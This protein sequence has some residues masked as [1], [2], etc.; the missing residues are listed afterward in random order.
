LQVAIEDGNF[1]AFQT[2]TLNG[3]PASFHPLM[4]F[5][6]LSPEILDVF[7]LYVPRMR[8]FTSEPSLLV[9]FFLLPAA[10]GLLLNERRWAMASG[11]LIVFCLSSFSGSVQ[12]SIA[13]SLI[14][15]IASFFF[16]TR[17]VFIS[18]P[19]LSAIIIIF[20]FV[21]TGGE[22]FVIFDTTLGNSSSAGFLSKGNSLVVRGQG[23]VD[24]FQEAIRSPLGTAWQRTLPLPIILSAMLSA[25]WLGAF[26]L[27]S[28]F[29]KLIYAID[30][31]E[32]K[33]D[34]TIYHRTSFALFFG[35]FCTIFT[36]N[37]YAML[38]Y[39]GLILLFLYYKCVKVAI[40]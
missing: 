6:L 30:M 5:G 24:G 7:G 15:V 10:L 18:L 21:T 31:I 40:K 4:L 20:L 23:I 32:K 11:M 3:L 36:F 1:V 26:L 33:H 27:L 17:F 34:R 35:V 28:F 12:V 25:G 37:D 8:S 13:F 39:S 19:L 2:D 16:A 29:F 9:A 38:N 22:W 14:Y